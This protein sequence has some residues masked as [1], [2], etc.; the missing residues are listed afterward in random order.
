M[1]VFFFKAFERI[2]KKKRILFKF[3]NLPALNLK[4]T[5]GIVK[6]CFLYLM[7]NGVHKSVIMIA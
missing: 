1:S 2:S 6:Y 4:L 5:T 7:E 3:F